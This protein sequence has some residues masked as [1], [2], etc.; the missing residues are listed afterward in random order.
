MFKQ[1]RI[2]TLLLATLLP[3]LPIAAQNVAWK[4]SVEAL[5]NDEYRL[6]LTATIPTDYHMYDMGP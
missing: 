1:T 6:V 4:S 5:G 2:F 3:L